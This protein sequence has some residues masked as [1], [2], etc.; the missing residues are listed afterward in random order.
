MPL[1][2]EVP[3]EVKRGLGREW[4]W[5]RRLWVKKNW[6][7]IVLACVGTIVALVLLI[8]GIV[9]YS[10]RRPCYFAHL[11][12]LL[13]TEIRIGSGECNSKWLAVFDL[14]RYKNLKSVVIGDASYKYVNEL[15]MIGL[16]KLES[17]EIGMSNFLYAS[18]ELKSI[19]IQKGR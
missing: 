5:V 3:R 11:L 16:S 6:K 10:Q 8:I 9:W 1:L 18:L 19:L 15:K 13:V 4:M 2:K 17:V 14:S 12:P 7:C